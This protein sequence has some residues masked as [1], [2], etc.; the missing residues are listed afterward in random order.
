MSLDPRARA[1]AI[2]ELRSLGAAADGL[3]ESLA[4]VRARLLALEA[5]LA[6]EATEPET[7]DPI[8]AGPAP[9]D[10]PGGWRVAPS[11]HAW[12]VDPPPLRDVPPLDFPSLYAWQSDALEAWYAAG[13]V[14]VV[15]AVTGAGK[16][17]LGLG[18][19]STRC[20]AVGASSS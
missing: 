8:R 13:R 19:W 9:V 10:E 5:L 16:T 4:D 2:V 6:D 7:L 20:N 11:D 17:R 18:R 14:G 15:E 1:H 3:A 12:Q